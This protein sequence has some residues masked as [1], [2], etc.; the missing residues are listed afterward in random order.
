[1]NLPQRCQVSHEPGGIEYVVDRNVEINDDK[2]G[3]L[4]GM[5]L[6]NLNEDWSQAN[7]LAAKMPAKLAEM[8]DLFTMEFT[9]NCYQGEFNRSK[10]RERRGKSLLGF[11][12]LLLFK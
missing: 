11:L 7:D 4:A 8:K 9:K 12:C 2:Y 5:E 6:N 3:F 1:M 10:R